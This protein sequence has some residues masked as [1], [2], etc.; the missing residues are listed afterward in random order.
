[1]KFLIIKRTKMQLLMRIVLLL[2]TMAIFTRD[3]LPK[4]G[5]HA[6]NGRMAQH[7]GNRLRM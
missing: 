3:A 1:M 2:A 5:T 7:P 6:S 4:D